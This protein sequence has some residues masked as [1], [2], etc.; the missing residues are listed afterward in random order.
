[1]VGLRSLVVWVRFFKI[2]TLFLVGR[3]MLPMEAP[4]A[5][6]FVVLSRIVLWQHV[7]DLRPF[8]GITKEK[9]AA[10]IG[11]QTQDS[12]LVYPTASH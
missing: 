12:E 10:G 3:L 9:W 2:D 8:G 4:R 7:G 5:Y 1:M 6:S 11:T